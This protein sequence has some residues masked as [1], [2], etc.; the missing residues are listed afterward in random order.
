[1]T[2]GSSMR[3]FTYDAAGNIEGYSD[4]RNETVRR[5]PEKVGDSRLE[6]AKQASRQPLERET[7]R[8]LPKIA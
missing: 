6:K 3:S 7:L 5:K 1:V 4:P 2:L 8:P